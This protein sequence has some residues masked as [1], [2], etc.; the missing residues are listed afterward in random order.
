MN[1]EKYVGLDVHESSTVAAAHNER[2]KRV[3]ESILETESETIRKTQRSH[4]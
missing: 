2:G 3:M 4:G 1:E